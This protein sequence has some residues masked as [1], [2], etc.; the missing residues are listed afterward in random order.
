MMALRFERKLVV[1]RDALVRDHART[2]WREWQNVPRSGPSS[3][4]KADWAQKWRSACHESSRVRRLTSTYLV[5]SITRNVAYEPLFERS[6]YDG[7]LAA[8]LNKNHSGLGRSHARMLRLVS[9]L[10]K[11]LHTDAITQTQKGMRERTA[12]YYL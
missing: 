5:R 2:K 9:D 3:R 11:G 1:N 12:T 6:V 4:A 8:F 7:S 10:N